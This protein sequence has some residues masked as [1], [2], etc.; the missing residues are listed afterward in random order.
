MNLIYTQYIHPYGNKV[1][2]HVFIR[3]IQDKRMVFLFCENDVSILPITACAC[4]FF[5][6]ALSFMYQIYFQTYLT[7]SETKS[8]PVGNGKIQFFLN[9]KKRSLVFFQQTL[10][11]SYVFNRLV[12]YRQVFIN[13][14]PA[15]F[16]RCLC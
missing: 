12:L 2:D 11:H 1:G 13:S 6:L 15:I 14:N 4:A 5:S 9:E 10:S 16:S 7:V 8:G 3:I